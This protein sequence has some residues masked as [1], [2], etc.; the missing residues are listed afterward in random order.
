MLMAEYRM[1]FDEASHFPLAVAFALREA[2]TARLGLPRT[3]GPDYIARAMI[4]AK[5]KAEA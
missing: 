3:G 5:R 2:R 4:D 1:L